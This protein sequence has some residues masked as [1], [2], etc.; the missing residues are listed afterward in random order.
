MRTRLVEFLLEHK[1]KIITVVDKRTADSVHLQ[2]FAAKKFVLAR[3]SLVGCES[4]K[5]YV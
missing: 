1:H 4:L 5:I 3:I 2:V